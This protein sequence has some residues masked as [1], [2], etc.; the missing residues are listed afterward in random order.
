MLG[1]ELNEGSG[2]AVRQL[3]KDEIAERTELD[4]KREIYGTKKDDPRELAAD[5]AAMANA[6]GGVILLGVD[7]QDSVA[8]A[9]VP[10]EAEKRDS[11]L[12][13]IHE[14]VAQRVAPVPVIYTEWI[15]VDGGGVIAIVIP[16][17]RGAPHAVGRDGSPTNPYLCWPRR[18]GTRKRYLS[19]FEIADA[20]SVRA[21]QVRGDRQRLR[22]VADD[23]ERLLDRT[24][25]RVWLVGAVVPS[26]P[27][28]F[29]LSEWNS[30]R[31]HQDLISP[32]MRVPAEQ[33]F[34]QWHPTNH[35][36]RLRRLRLHTGNPDP[37]KRQVGELHTDGS[38]ALAAPVAQRTDRFREWTDD[39][40]VASEWVFRKLFGVL[41]GLVFLSTS[42]A[43][44][45]GADSTLRLSLNAAGA[46]VGSFY[47]GGST[48]E[49]L[50]TAVGED[51]VLERT[52]DLDA[53]SD[54]NGYRLLLAS[55]AGDLWNGMG[56]Q[57]CPYL[58]IDGEITQQGHQFFGKR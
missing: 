13:R 37:F 45:R 30:E 10:I 42:I 29:R 54:P 26:L 19:E 57:A 27:G 2:E 53:A 51:I 31:I 43:G 50:D 47:L 46:T 4:F 24:D 14:I 5:V 1:L 34:D 33:R 28:S 18:D 25:D 44:A 52:V 17:S 21:R 9:L 40:A 56:W 3:V 35:A 8:S 12:R 20:Y 22:D 32:W 16:P 49:A 55:V 11:E 36:P 48:F 23:V 39:V 6:V 41:G 38:A 15:D 7:E 58:T